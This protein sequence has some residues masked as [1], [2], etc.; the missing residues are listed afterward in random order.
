MSLICLDGDSVTLPVTFASAARETG[1]AKAKG[2]SK[3]LVGVRMGPR[4]LAEMLVPK[5]TPFFALL[6]SGSEIFYVQSWH[7]FEIYCD[8]EFAQFPVACFANL[9]CRSAPFGYS[10]V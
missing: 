3:I 2:K 6:S 5:D 1:E 8:P 7:V 10:S 9:A 4:T